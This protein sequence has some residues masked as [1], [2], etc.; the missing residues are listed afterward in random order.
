MSVWYKPLSIC[1]RGSGLFFWCF[2]YFHLTYE[3]QKYYNIFERQKSISFFNFLQKRMLRNNAEHFTFLLSL[4]RVFLLLVLPLPFEECFLVYNI[5][6]ELSCTSHQGAHKLC[7][8]LDCLLV[9]LFSDS[10]CHLTFEH[11]NYNIFVIQKSSVKNVNIFKKCHCS[12][13]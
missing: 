1:K 11:H 9:C 4:F 7:M 6:Q 12:N 3:R 2:K 13:V 8:A 10:F 5:Y